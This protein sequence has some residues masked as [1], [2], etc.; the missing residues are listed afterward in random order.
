MFGARARNFQF[1]LMLATALAVSL[2][3][4]AGRAYTDEQQQA[5]TGDAFRLCGA[6]IPDVERVSACMNRNK[7]QLSP[8]CRAHFRPESAAARI[9]AQRPL[10]IRAAG[11]RKHVRANQR[12]SKR[13]ARP[14][15]G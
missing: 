9:A 8:G 15:E 6:E 11:S 12:K 3:P 7:S 10:S 5:C 2:W 4:A 14:R 1:G 13:S